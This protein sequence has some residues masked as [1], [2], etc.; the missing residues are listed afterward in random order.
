MPNA[1]VFDTEARAIGG[2]RQASV[3]VPPAGV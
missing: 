3:T 2:I 1:R